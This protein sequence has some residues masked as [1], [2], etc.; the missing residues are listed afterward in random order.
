MAQDTAHQRGNEQAAEKG[1]GEKRRR[2]S[3]V[4]KRAQTCFSS[5]CEDPAALAA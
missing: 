3:A 5:G 4:E 1:R 2:G